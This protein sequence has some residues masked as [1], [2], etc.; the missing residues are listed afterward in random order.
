MVA[1]PQLMEPPP[2]LPAGVAGLVNGTT[3]AA[4]ERRALLD[5]ALAALVRRGRELEELERFVEGLAQLELVPEQD[6]QP[7]EETIAAVIEVIE[8]LCAWA[9]TVAEERAD[10]LNA[11]K[12]DLE[13]L[14]AGD[15]ALAPLAR[16]VCLRQEEMSGRIQALAALDVERLIARLLVQVARQRELSKQEKIRLLKAIPD[17][18]PIDI[19][20]S[21]RRADW[22]S[23]TPSTH[24]RDW[25]R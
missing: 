23:D 2:R 21:T 16:Q 17:H 14:C 9:A 18:R 5:E 6:P 15:E 20:V 1:L 7:N 11:L 22:Y 10:R 19:P 13:D 3:S 12:N 8:E 24:R 4:G 25:Y